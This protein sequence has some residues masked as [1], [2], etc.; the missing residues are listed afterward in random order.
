[1]LHILAGAAHTQ[2][3]A[4]AENY[5]KIPLAFTANYGQLDSRVKFTTRSGGT[6]MFFTQEGTTFLFSRETEASRN[7]RAGSTPVKGTIPAKDGISVDNKPGNEYEYYAL[8]LH[9]LGA[10]TN[11]E[12]NGE[13]RL[14]W[15]NNY[16][17]GR[18]PDNWHT[19]VPN[20]SKIRV[21]NIYDGIDLVY[22][23]GKNI[24]KYD[25]LVKPGANPDDVLLKYD[26]GDFLGNE[27]L[28]IN[29]NNELEIKTPLGNLLEGKPYSYQII[30]GNNIEIDVQYEIV[31]LSEN[32]YKFSIGKYN[33][34]HPLVIDPVLC[35]SS[36]LS[37][38]KVD[39]GHSIAV[40][41]AGNTYITG[42]TKSIDFPTT[43]GAYDTTLNG[44]K[45]D[46]FVTKLNSS[47]SK[48][49][50]STYIGA[51]GL[52]KGYGI[53]VDTECY[54]YI[55]G[56]TYSDSFPTTLNAFDA[57]H[58]G[59]F[60]VFITKLNSEGNALIY[61]TFLGGSDSD[62]GNSITIDA[63][64]NVYVTGYTKSDDF[65]TTTDAYD[66]DY[67]E[68][69]DVFVSKL[70]PSKSDSLS[71]LYS[72]YLG[73]RGNDE[74]ESITVDA[75][76]NVY[77]TGY[78]F[79]I[80]FPTTTDKEQNGNQDV[81]V[82]KLDPSKSGS[83]SLLYSTY[84]GGSGSDVGNSITVDASGNVYVTGYTF[85]INFP[86]T[87]DKEQNGNEDV[88]VSKLDPSKS[89]SLSLLYSTYLGG[90]TEDIGIGITVNTV[91]CVYIIGYTH[92]G[93][94]PTTPDAF[95][96]N[97]KGGKYDV[98]MSMLDPS[99]SDSLSL[100][101]ST[102][103]GGSK[104]DRGH[105]I[106]LDAN[107]G[108][109][110]TGKTFSNDFPTTSGAF[111]ETHNGGSDIFVSK[112]ILD[113]NTGVNDNKK[114]ITGYRLFQNYPN[115]FNSATTIRF[116]IPAAE[117]VTIYIYNIAGQMIKTLAS[118]YLPVSTH[119]IIWDGTN[120]NGLRVSSAVYLYRLQAGEFS[121][122]KKMLFV[123]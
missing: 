5:G 16:F 61:S 87:T 95:Q 25:F 71:L 46:V 59:N 29:S 81:F 85:S 49:I 107:G 74:G 45:E 7:N 8:K 90:S 117:Y 69:Q 110:I 111:N 89:D 73:G 114:L 6:T 60:D 121:A 113:T 27:L 109:Y 99:K 42:F 120:D 38:E 23:G 88:F 66:E 28:K 51:D 76:G 86:T 102:Y 58:N 116:E 19:D 65:S 15:N 96:K 40:D 12:V 118:G 56:V 112:F 83:L 30:N 106:T 98:F 52:D 54:A 44:Y 41:F 24:I 17:I 119:T 103:L 101:Y 4:V 123:K 37:G 34:A 84:L 105:D 100:L 72:T 3:I 53:V 80:D 94:F 77:V 36:L 108:V 18:N 9:F 67:N 2:M 21:N 39:E 50:Y 82:S 64:G 93:N 62:E 13:Y 57:S 22:Y 31:N 43:P 92:S 47:G 55:T 97:H 20:Y 78:T 1:M 122:V 48:L 79:S 32:I 11:P 63:S 26:F 91:G 68:N 33:R 75:S 70:D 14:P 10:N 115:P 104:E 35:Y